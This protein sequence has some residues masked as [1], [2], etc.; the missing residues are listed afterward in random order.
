MFPKYPGHYKFCAQT[1]A[2]IG[3][4][5][6]RVH[7]V[8][9]G[10]L[11]PLFSSQSVRELDPMIRKYVDI[12]VSRVGETNNQKGFEIG[13]IFRC[14][15]VDIISEYTYSEGFETL[16]KGDLDAPFFVGMRSSLRMSWFF[17][18]FPPL[19]DIMVALP[20]SWI[21]GIVPS[22]TLGVIDAQKVREDNEDL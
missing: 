12:V 15:S 3:L 8:R 6:S 20:Y 19:Q 1:E 21:K 7:K 16:K 5:D 10:V 4:M 11:D 2:G 9:R 22:G 14:L 17:N 18:W 13:K